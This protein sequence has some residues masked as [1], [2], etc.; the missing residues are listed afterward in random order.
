MRRATDSD[1]SFAYDP[2]EGAGSIAAVHDYAAL[3][4]PDHVME[5]ERQ[6]ASQG[7]SLGVIKVQRSLTWTERSEMNHSQQGMDS[8][9]CLHWTPFSITVAL[10]SLH[11]AL[12]KLSRSWSAL[13]GVHDKR[14]TMIIVQLKPVSP[15]RHTCVSFNPSKAHVG[16]CGSMWDH[17]N[18]EAHVGPCGSMWDHDNCEAHDRSIR[19]ISTAAKYKLADRRNGN[20]SS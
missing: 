16:P 4:S 6:A 5:D 1:T 7:Q 3:L 9:L 18:R 12:I 15:I 13:Y 11:T 14:D 19:T 2:Q 10:P 17:D 20:N 8:V